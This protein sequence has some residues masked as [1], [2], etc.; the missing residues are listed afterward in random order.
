MCYQSLNSLIFN[1]HLARGVVARSKLSLFFNSRIWTFHLEFSSSI[2]ISHLASSLVLSSCSS[3][4]LSCTAIDI[5]FL[6]FSILF[7]IFIAFF[8]SSF[9]SYA[10]L[11]IRP[12]LR[13]SRIP[14]AFR[15]I[16]SSHFLMASNLAQS[17]PPIAFMV[18]LGLG[19]GSGSS[20][21]DRSPVDL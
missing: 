19:S 2:L 9:L 17:P 14:L 7:F 10:N 21:D 11:D 1:D 15:F 4:S 12:C 6:I 18:F 13:L 8:S 16:S 3:H 5:L 20:D